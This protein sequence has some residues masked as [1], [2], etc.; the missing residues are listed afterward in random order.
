MGVVE[1]DTKRLV[2]V[3]LALTEKKEAAGTEGGWQ[4]DKGVKITSRGL[5]GVNWRNIVD[6]KDFYN[7]V[8]S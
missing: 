1:S 7:N 6:W 2:E 3:V 5:G 8:P 4:E